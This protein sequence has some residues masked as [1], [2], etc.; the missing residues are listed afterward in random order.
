MVLL[1]KLAFGVLAGS[2]V[3]AGHAAEQSE[4]GA[5]RIDP[6]AVANGGGTSNGGGYSL[7]GTFGQ[8]A[9]ATLAASSYVMNDGIWG[10]AVGNAPADEIFSNGFEP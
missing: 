10:P 6:A 9:A 7:R 4:G 3:L 5:Y 8:A 2:V 1:K